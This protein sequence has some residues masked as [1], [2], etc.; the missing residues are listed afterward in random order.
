MRAS[1]LDFIAAFL[2]AL[3]LSIS[4]SV[5]LRAENRIAPFERACSSFSSGQEFVSKAVSF[6]LLH[7]QARKCESKAREYFDQCN[8]DGQYER[9]SERTHANILMMVVLSK[10]SSV[11]RED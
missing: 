11:S 3:L 1:R 7:D 6:C 2:C 8:F 4:L 5:P 9:I 10:A